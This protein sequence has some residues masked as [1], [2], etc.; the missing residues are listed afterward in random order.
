[1]LHEFD[2]KQSKLDGVRYFGGNDILSAQFIYER[3]GSVIEL[4]GMDRP[5]KVAST[6]WDGIYVNEANELTLAQWETLGGRTD[7]PSLGKPKP[8]SLLLGDC[9]PDAPNHWIR[10]RAAAGLLQLW[11]SRHEDNP[12]MWDLERRE[13]TEGGRRY[14]ARLDRLTGVRY[15]RNRLGRWAAAEGQVLDRWDRSIH[16]IAREQLPSFG[17]GPNDTHVAGVD[18]GWTKPGVMD[19]WRIG[20][21]GQMAQVHEV[22]QTRRAIDWWIEKGKDLQARYGVRKWLC[23]PSEPA[24]IA[25]FNSAGLN[26]VK[27]NNAILPGVQL[28]QARLVPEDNGR[29]RLYVVA[30]ALEAIDA[31]LEERGE[32]TSSLDE[33]DA[34]V[35][36]KSLS[37]DAKD[38]PEDANN[39]A[40]DTWRY[41]A[42]DLEKPSAP[43]LSPVLSPHT[44][45][46]SHA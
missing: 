12:A 6:E 38:A 17:F 3:T 11:D 16:L 4:T 40:M 25:A 26:A 43:V 34:W 15:L 9:N 29:P 5:T 21:D 23:D 33:V 36:A 18:W 13:W 41:V 8:P 31:E 42:L 20:N 10:R 1:V 2:G 24:N 35:W 37:G 39:H 30:D 22:Y 45:T 7:R 27:A 14:L 32:P 46:W 28:L 19:V 44:S